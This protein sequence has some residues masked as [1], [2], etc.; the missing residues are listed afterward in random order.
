[1]T[2][3][4]IPEFLAGFHLVPCEEHKPPNYGGLGTCDGCAFRNGKTSKHY[5][6]HPQYPERKCGEWLIYKETKETNV[7]NNQQPQT[8][9]G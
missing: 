6:R 7:R 2:L 3:D 8:L 9:A 4:D 5:C 1:M